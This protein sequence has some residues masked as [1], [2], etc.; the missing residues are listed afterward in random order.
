MNRKDKKNN[1]KLEKIK[2][3]VITSIANQANK[4]INEITLETNLTADLNFDSLDVVE[5]LMD[6]EDKFN[7][8]IPESDLTK[9]N[10]VNDIVEYLYKHTK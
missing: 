9:I 1:E 6:L 7:I 8:E 3:I 2:E 5:L 10:I 4:E